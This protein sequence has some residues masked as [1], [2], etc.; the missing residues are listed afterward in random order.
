MTLRSKNPLLGRMSRGMS[1]MLT[2]K[3]QELIA[4]QKEINDIND[5]SI[6]KKVNHLHNVL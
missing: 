6:R 4:M 2:R 3:Q 5:D 1:V